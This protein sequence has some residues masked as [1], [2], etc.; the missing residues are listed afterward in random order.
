MALAKGKWNKKHF[1]LFVTIFALVFWGRAQ[2]TESAEI[3]V[4]ACQIDPKIFD[5]QGNLDKHIRLMK[6]A[7]EN[8]AKLIVFPE[9]SIPGYCY[10]SW[11]EMATHGQYI[12][13][14]ITNAINK[15]CKDLN[16][17]AV[18]GMIE[19]EGMGSEWSYYNAAVLIGPAGVIGKYRKTHL[20]FLGIDRFIKAGN[21]PYN[22]YDTPIAKIGLGICYD[23]R[24]PEQWRTMALKGAEIL[25]NITNLPTG[26]DTHPNLL[27]PTRA[28]EN[29]VFVISC[30]RVGNE[31]GWEFIG[32][33]QVID[34]TGKVLAEAS[35]DKEEII[36]GT[37]DPA[38][39]REKYIVV[40][41][42]EYEIDLVKDRR[43]DLYEVG[44]K[45]K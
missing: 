22:V 19:R 10:T 44:E 34:L 14:P 20:P 28:L 31:R 23:L 26:A 35:R 8:G 43:P 9:M 37:I 18:I 13:G 16:V 7:A 36:Y 45:K 24:F 42:G 15:V 6:Q 4:A 27:G 39:A 3:K 41:P 2:Q 21:L 29:R 12:P 1:I 25:V 40:K 32:R 30:D 38:K 33:S 11:S 5:L 17:Y